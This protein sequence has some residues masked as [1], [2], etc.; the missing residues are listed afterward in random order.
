M[1]PNAET[2]IKY[3]A[4]NPSGF[5]TTLSKPEGEEPGYDALRGSDDELPVTP[6]DE[7]VITTDR[8]PGV[9]DFTFMELEFNVNPDDD[10]DTDP[11]TVK[12]VFELSDGTNVTI[13]KTVSVT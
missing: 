9:D 7:L 8:K 10:D 12:I 3:D 4:E 11:T 1:C 5:T 13:Y 6:D 2:T